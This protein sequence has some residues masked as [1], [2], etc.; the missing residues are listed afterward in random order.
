MTSNNQQ[1][2]HYHFSQPR[3]LPDLRL[4]LACLYS[5]PPHQHHVQ[6][7]HQQQQQ[8]QHHTLGQAQEFLIYIQSRNMRRKLESLIQ[9][10]RD[11]AAGPDGV[12]L[13]PN[14]MDNTN[15][16]SGWA[17]EVII[18]GSSWLACL[19]L[20]CL[21]QQ[22]QQNATSAAAASSCFAAS[23]AERLF[24][25]QTIVHRLL[26]AKLR[27]GVDLEME[28]ALVSD[29]K[30]QQQQ[31]FVALMFHQLQQQPP[32]P[33]QQM[34]EHYRQSM[35]PQCGGN[36]HPLIH[37]VLSQYH[38]PTD[39]DEDRLK[40]ELALL[41]L[42]SILYATAVDSYTNTH[43]NNQHH[44][45]HPNHDEDSTAVGPLLNSLGSAI[46]AI[47][48]RLRFPPTAS[49]HNSKHLN[50]VVVEPSTPTNSISISSTVPLVTMV[51]Q[52][53]TLVMQTASMQMQQQQQQHQQLLHL[54]VSS[55]CLRACLSA[56]PDICCGTTTGGGSRNRMSVDP[57]CLQEATR[58]LRST[59]LVQL[60]D[61]LQQHFHDMQQLQQHSAVQEERVQENILI[62]CERWARFLPLPLEFLKHTIPLA[63]RHIGAPSQQQQH[64]SFTGIRKAAFSYL[65]AIFEGATWSV[66][67][68]L[69]KNVGA[70]PEQQGT[71]QQGG[72]KRQSSRSKKRQQELIKDRTTDTLVEEAR[73]EAHHRGAMACETT[74][75]VWEP[76]Q[77]AYRAALQE[78]NQRHDQLVAEH[79]NSNHGHDNNSYFG[80]DGDEDDNVED[81]IEIEG[82]GPIG[83]LAACANACLPHL[84]RNA[85]SHELFLA[86]SQE[87]QELCRS[88]H[89]VVRAFS[90]ESIFS[91]HAVLLQHLV[92]NE[93]R[94]S[95]DA[96]L[97]PAIV[98][99]FFKCAMSLATSCGYPGDY[100]R[101]MA[102]MSDEALEVERNDVRDI[103]RTVTVSERGG[104]TSS[105]ASSRQPFDVTL[106]VLVHLLRAIH[107][108]IE[109][110][111]DSKRLFQ[112]SVV[113]CFSALA[114]PL[115]QLS[116]CYAKSNQPPEAFDILMLALQI[117]RNSLQIIIDAFPTASPPEIFP[118]CRVAN[119]AIASLSPL[120]SNLCDIPQFRDEV[121]QILRL[122]LA[123]ASISITNIPELAVPSLLG[124]S[125]Y[126]IRCVLMWVFVEVLCP[127]ACF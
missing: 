6:Q 44:H 126:D 31:E 87:F 37:A 80:D 38:V 22:Q 118:G 104:S 1:P 107:G 99:H 4:A 120:L 57:K 40:G 72:K 7:Q 105:A 54:Q 102:A 29:N 11:R 66:E 69:A 77:A 114:K 56:L 17:T 113:H 91:L 74:V 98:D 65:V 46:A 70:A 49:I 90:M 51:S 34:M 117:F 68:I 89:R 53:L 15:Q 16:V 92:E 61:I 93:Q 39:A 52:A 64:P 42:T 14:M 127:D 82:E 75:M 122:S 26:R 76:L 110:S 112:E 97:Q 9:R 73:M 84:L 111:R 41:T 24:A 50:Q 58:E 67:Q 125:L 45:Q 116:N 119:I 103:L 94:S 48:M 2:Q 21:Q 79:N 106:Q 78:V 108:A 96:N 18:A 12:G 63:S 30:E 5:L 28:V 71:Q 8:Q 33:L 27:E 47:A 83:C 43:N 101:N 81:E 59:G 123:L 109:E 13:P 95:L 100:F 23:N 25:A 35:H 19:S 85:S 88:H 124:H 86:I 55:D 32:L 20:L 3:L 121:Y 10:Q 60:W 36:H 62:I 115:N